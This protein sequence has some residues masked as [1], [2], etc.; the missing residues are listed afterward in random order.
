MPTIL[1]HKEIAY[2]L[3]T[4]AVGFLTSFAL[5][6]MTLNLVV[7][8]RIKVNVPVDII[9]PVSVVFIH[10]VAPLRGHNC[11]C[12]FLNLLFFLFNLERHILLIEI[13]NLN[14]VS[15]VEV[16]VFHHFIHY[17]A[18]LLISNEISY[19]ATSYI[20]NDTSNKTCCS[21]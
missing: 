11:I 8:V 7:L 6:V 17:V 15:L 1:A 2:H 16:W 4:C 10:L 20:F 21:F 19:Q 12:R 3:E 9:G 14:I 13:F 18:L 5:L